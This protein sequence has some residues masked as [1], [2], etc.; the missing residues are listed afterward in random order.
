MNVL[1]VDYRD[2]D[3]PAKFTESLRTTGFGVLKNHPIPQSLVEEIYREWLGFFDTEAKH[4]YAFSRRRR[5]ASSPPPSPRRPRATRSRTSRSSST[6]PVGPL[7]AE[8]ATR[9]GATTSI[10]NGVAC[11][12]LAWVDDQHAAEV[13][14]PLLDAPAPR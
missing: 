2:P 14:A 12:L 3:A 6:L 1:V 11:E 13:K 8:V 4:R 7:P 9:R 10:A 5:T